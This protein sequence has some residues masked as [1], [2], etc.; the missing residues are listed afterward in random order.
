MRAHL[1]AEYLPKG[2][3]LDRSALGRG[4]ANRLANLLIPHFL[5]YRLRRSSLDIIGQRLE[6]HTKIVLRLG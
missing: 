4:T 1:P 5:R 3:V 2:M 6:L